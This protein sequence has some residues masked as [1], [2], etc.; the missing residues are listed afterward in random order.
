M[1]IQSS[2]V[3][4]S[5]DSSYQSFLWNPREPSKRVTVWC[6]PIQQPSRSDVNPS[7]EVGVGRHLVTWASTFLNAS[8][9]SHP[10]Y[11]PRSSKISLL[12]LVTWSPDKVV[13]T[14]S[15]NWKFGAQPF[16]ACQGTAGTQ[17][18]WFWSW[19]GERN[20]NQISSQPLAFIAS[21]FGRLFYGHCQRNLLLF[22]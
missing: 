21:L 14:Y 6:H 13:R 18:V 16:S 7:I 3:H 5:P 9:C 1:N 17:F 20:Q 10:H 19:P 2:K 4:L 8:K 11:V 12:S 22:T 15:G